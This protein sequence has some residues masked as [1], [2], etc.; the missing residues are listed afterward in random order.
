MPPIRIAAITDEFSPDLDVAL[1]AMHAAGVQGVELRTVRGINIVDLSDRDIDDALRAAERRGMPIVS[2]ASPLLKCVLPDAPPVDGRFQQDV[3]GSPFTFDDQPRLT[4]RVFELATRTGAR[5]VRVFSY[6]RTIDPARCE[7][8]VVDALRALADEAATRGVTIGLENEF[9]CNVGTARESVRVLQRLP[10]PNLKLIWD[11][12]NAF[13]LGETPFPDGYQ[14]LPQD[15]LLHVHVKDCVLEDG[16]PVWGPPGTS[17][18]WAGQV[19]ALTRDGYRGWLSLETHW[20]GPSGNK[21]EASDIC[22]RQLRQL[23]AAAAA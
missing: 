20:T 4:R 14:T 1:D 5:I 13:I 15:R 22:A 10:H 7:D 23:I 9:A 3:F 8:R 11:P 16:R 19:R 12:A 21:L 18:D 2:L 6:W 17:I